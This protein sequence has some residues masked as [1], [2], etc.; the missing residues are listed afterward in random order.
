MGF[1]SWKTADTS[2]SIANISSGKHK[3]VSVYLLSPD[4]NHIAERAYQGYGRFGGVDAYAWLAKQNLGSDVEHL[5]LYDDENELRALGIELQ[6]EAHSRITLPLKFSF[7]KCAI[8]DELPESEECPLYCKQDIFIFYI[9]WL[10][11]L[12]IGNTM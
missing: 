9:Q 12:L 2:E 4:G 10:I 6:Y 11:F 8:Y 5:C 7:N 1:F 3:G